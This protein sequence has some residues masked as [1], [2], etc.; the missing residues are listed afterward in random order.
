VTAPSPEQIE[1]ARAN[2]SPEDRKEFDALLAMEVP[3]AS[4]LD[5]IPRTSPKF[6]APTHLRPLVDELERCRTEPV[7]DVTST[8]PRHGKTELFLHAIAWLLAN[9]PSEQIAYVTHTDRLARMKSGKAR[10]LALAAGVQ[11]S[12]ESNSKSDWRTGVGEGGVW[13]TSTGGAIVG[14][15][16]TKI[17]V[18]DPVKG[19]NDVESALQ[20]ENDYAW[21]NGDL[22]NRLEP[23]GSIFVNMARWHEDDLSG[24]LIREGWKHINLPAINDE[25]VPL[26]PER[27]PL[28][29]LAEIRAKS[30]YDWL[31][32]YMGTPRSREG[33]LFEG[34]KTYTKLP[35]TLN[36]AVGVDLAYTS[37]T[38]SDWSIAVVIGE[39]DGL[40]YVLD[41][42]RKQ[43]RADVFAGALLA[44]QKR[45][46]AATMRWYGSTT[47]LGSAD[48]LKMMGVRISGKLA[49]TDKFIRAQPVA[50]AWKAGRVLLPAQ[51]PW[52][53][54]FLEVV[55]NFTGVGD[56]NDDDVDALA[57]GFDILPARLLPTTPK[58]GSPEA[59]AAEHERMLEAA[60]QAAERR[61]LAARGGGFL[62]RDPF[63][64]PRGNR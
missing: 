21:F 11:I 27:W 3:A 5:F 2:L 29:A 40:W 48:L 18:D 15:G 38:S 47:E 36:V 19:R 7:R 12:N 54:A 6:V 33:K 10:Q 52:L 56:I 51:A 16:F 35:D 58:P 28:A 41:V 9:D 34:V 63:L 14:L 64:N 32:L 49:T 37:K 23:D 17:F 25:G 62:P 44:L 20:R 31:S 1:A 8:P 42:V 22:F 30:E 46:P 60:R 45:H 55:Q 43:V 57:A 26:W 59:I 4:L 13:A 24:R 50:A 39:H 53:E 61:S